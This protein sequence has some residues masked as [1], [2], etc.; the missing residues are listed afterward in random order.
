LQEKTQLPVTIADEPLS[1]VV[2]GSG[3]ALENID[4]LKYVMI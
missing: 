1:R 3:K 4:I 2:M